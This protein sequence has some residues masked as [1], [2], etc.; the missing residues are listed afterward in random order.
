MKK[1]MIEPKYRHK[2]ATIEIY[3]KQSG[4]F[5]SS[6]VFVGRTRSVRQELKKGDPEPLAAG[7]VLLGLRCE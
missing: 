6:E 5:G 7:A 4:L 1:A 2:A 3:V